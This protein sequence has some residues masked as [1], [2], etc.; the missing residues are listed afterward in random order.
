MLEKQ[1]SEGPLLPKP[2]VPPL[3]AADDVNGTLKATVK[4]LREFG[5]GPCVVDGKPCLGVT[6]LDPASGTRRMA[7]CCSIQKV[8]V[9]PEDSARCTQQRSRSTS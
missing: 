4:R 2:E 9:F 8:H 1:A 6:V 7:V 5:F 3:T